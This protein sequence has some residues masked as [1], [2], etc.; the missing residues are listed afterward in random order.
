MIVYNSGKACFLDHF[1]YS[2]YNICENQ[3]RLLILVFVL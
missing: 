3:N 2:V 1:V